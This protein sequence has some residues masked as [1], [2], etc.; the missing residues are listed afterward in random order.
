MKLLVDSELSVFLQLFEE[1]HV[2]RVVLDS[3]LFIAERHA[4]GQFVEVKRIRDAESL[5][6]SLAQ[7]HELLV[8]LFRETL[9]SHFVACSVDAFLQCVNVAARQGQGPSFLDCY[10]NTTKEVKK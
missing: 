2:Q 3:H 4:E 10:I 7:A 1:P 8:V 9:A 5:A 6:N